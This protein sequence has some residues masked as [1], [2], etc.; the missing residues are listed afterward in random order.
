MIPAILIILTIHII[1][2]I[3]WMLIKILSVVINVQRS[4]K[5]IVLGGC[6]LD[7]NIIRKIDCKIK[8]VLRELQENTD[9]TQR[10][11]HPYFIIIPV[12]S[13]DPVPYPRL[14]GSFP[15]MLRRSCR[16]DLPIPNPPD[17]SKAGTDI[18]HYNPW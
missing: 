10:G 2:A 16:W 1:I 3:R 9:A 11:L 15:E 5:A 18:V 8:I 13:A 12:A 4:H 6:Y 17:G 14:S 7:I